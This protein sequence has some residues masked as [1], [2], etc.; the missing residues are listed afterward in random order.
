MDT[1]PVRQFADV[2]NLNDLTN[3]RLDSAMLL[4]VRLV[5]KLADVLNGVDLSTVRVGD[6]VD[7]RARDARMLIA[8]GWAEVVDP[9]PIDP[10]KDPQT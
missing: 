10:A 8:E 9:H 6:C 5:R 1:K 7:V 3:V 2:I 4:R